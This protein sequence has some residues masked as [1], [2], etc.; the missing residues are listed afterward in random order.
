MDTRRNSQHPITLHRYL[1]SA[2]SILQLTLSP[3]RSCHGRLLSTDPPRTS[4]N[5]HAFHSTPLAHTPTTQF[6]STAIGAVTEQSA[7]EH[8][9]RFVAGRL[10]LTHA[11]STRSLGQPSRSRS[12]PPI[13]PIMSHSILISQFTHPLYTPHPRLPHPHQRL[14]PNHTHSD[15]S[16]H[17]PPCPSSH[18][19]RP[20]PLLIHPTLR[21]STPACT[22]TTK[23]IR[24][25]T[26]PH[27]RA[28]PY[29]PRS[30]APLVYPPTSP[31]SP[32]SF[33]QNRRCR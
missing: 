1:S 23:L 32:L 14:P 13:R 4:K 5:S 19:S 31:T 11:A 15:L 10:L 25:P 7:L 26:Y 6:R 27:P 28:T 12:R 16:T 3:S 21:L 30:H 33:G 2:R 20:T 9:C 22:P 18:H 24:N 8:S 17:H 29:L